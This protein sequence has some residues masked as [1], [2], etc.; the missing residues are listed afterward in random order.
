MTD[1]GRKTNKNLKSLIA[2]SRGFLSV[3]RKESKTI[4]PLGLSIAQFGVLE[5]LYH[6]GSLPVQIITE[7]TLT[8][9]G[10]MTMVIQ[11]LLKRELVEKL[12]NPK[13]KRSYLLKITKKGIKLFEEI[14]PPH[15]ENIN[16]IFSVLD[17]DEKDELIKI[18]KKL[19]DVY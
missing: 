18:M 16:K 7:K 15:L 5:I 10:N 6:K 14:F 11:N 12:E 1:C 3:R 13:D 9:S 8:T 2:L 17:E 4:K 19:G